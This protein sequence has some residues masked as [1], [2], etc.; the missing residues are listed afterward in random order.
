M[1]KAYILVALFVGAAFAAA[2]QSCASDVSPRQN[3]CNQAIWPR[4]ACPL[5]DFQSRRLARAAAA[6]PDRA[7]VSEAAKFEE[8]LDLT[9]APGTNRL[10]VAERWG[11]IWSFVNKKD[12]TKAD[13]ALEFKGAKD[14]KGQPMKQVIYAIHLSSQVQGQRLHLCDLDP[15]PGERGLAQRLARVA[16]HRQGRAAGHRPRFG[17]DHLRVAQRRPQRRLPQVRPRRLS[18]HRHRRRLR[19]RRRQ[20]HR[21]GPL[22]HPRQAAAHRRGPSR[23]PARPMDPEGQS[24][25]EHARRPPGNLRLRP[26]ATL[27]V[28]LRPQDR[29]LCGAAKSARIC[30]KWSTRSKKAATTA[31][32]SRK[33]RHPFRPERKKGPTPILKSV[34]E[35]SHTDFRSITGGFVYRGKRLPE[36]QAHIIYGDFDTGRI[37]G[38]NSPALTKG[39]ARGAFEPSRTRPHHLPHRQ[40]RRGRRRRTLLP[41]LHRRRHPSTRQGR[42][43]VDNAAKF[44]RKLSET[45]IFASTKDHKVAPGVIPYSVNAQLWGDHACEGTLPRHPRRRPDRLR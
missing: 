16:L 21:P 36:L 13:L 42:H 11:K 29:R 45:G 30:G 3:T 25:R 20:Q 33:A 17:E 23:R 32:R 1:R 22:Q 28:Q 34:V 40:L 39:G 38:I 15:Q 5:D 9:F 27:A 37:W 26:A 8:P 35:H 14:S 4:E 24:V 18:L 2:W 31:G 12:V 44:P 10:F 41:R 7:G 19:H 43:K 6:L